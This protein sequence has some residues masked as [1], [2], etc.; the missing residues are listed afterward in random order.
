MKKNP[1]IAAVLNFILP[2]AGLWYTGHRVWGAVNFGIVVAVPLALLLF[3]TE[4]FSQA[5]HYVVLALAAASAGLAHAVATQTGNRAP[6]N[7]DE[8]TSV[9]SLGS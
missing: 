4:F 1:T 7:G 8:R 3:A 9:K 6:A 5:V 2:G